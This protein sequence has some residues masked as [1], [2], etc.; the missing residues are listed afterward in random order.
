MRKEQKSI[1]HSFGGESQETIDEVSEAES[2]RSERIKR[3]IGS[4]V[5]H[6]AKRVNQIS[7]RKRIFQLKF[8]YDIENN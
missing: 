4:T 8:A 6:N 2:Q 3:C 7:Q 1:S 5:M